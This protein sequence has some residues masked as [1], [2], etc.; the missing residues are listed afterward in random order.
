MLSYFVMPLQLLSPTIASRFLRPSVSRDRLVRQ[1]NLGN[2]FDVEHI[3]SPMTGYTG[4]EKLSVIL[5]CSRSNLA[6]IR[7]DELQEEIV[8]KDPARMEEVL[9]RLSK[10]QEDAERNRVYD[11][12]TKVQRIMDLMGFQIR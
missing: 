1:E 6:Y 7:Q 10:L 2:A 9:N 12:S 11:L 5:T 4:H 3:V 8:Q